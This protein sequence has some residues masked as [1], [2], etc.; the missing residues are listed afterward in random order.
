ML[1]IVDCRFTYG[2]S[3][4]KKHKK[5]RK[6]KKQK[7][8]NKNNNKKGKN[9]KKKTTAKSSAFFA[10]LVIARKKMNDD[11]FFNEQFNELTF[12]FFECFV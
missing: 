12:E 8:K 11:I 1:I 2:E 7:N 10:R 6:T 9:K 4:C 5:K 3:P